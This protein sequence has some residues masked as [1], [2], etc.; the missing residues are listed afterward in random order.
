MD[1]EGLD[2]V[3]L[4]FVASMSLN[5]SPASLELEQPMLVCRMYLRLCFVSDK[6]V[7]Q[8]FERIAKDEKKTTDCEELRCV[9]G[10]VLSQESVLLASA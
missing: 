4:G 3:C 5:S 2:I 9:G 8:H 7:A 6:E 10:Q 1:V